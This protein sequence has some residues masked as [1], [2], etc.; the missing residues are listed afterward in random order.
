MSLIIYLGLLTALTAPAQVAAQTWTACNPLNQTNCPP[1]TALGISNATYNF[2][3]S[4]AGSTWNTT[5]GN[6]VY[7][8]QGAEF[9]ISQKGEAPTI[10]SNFYIFFG[11]V[12]VWMKA[13][14]GQGV[15]STIVL[16]SDDLDEVDLEIVGSN[17]THIENNY[18]GKGNTT[19]EAQRAIWY[20]IATPAQTGFHNYTTRWTN[21]SLEWYV[22]GT[23]VRTLNYQDANGGASY[24]QTPMNVRIGVW[25]AGDPSNSNW[26]VA[27]AGG[28]IDYNKGPYTMYLQSARITDFSSGAEYK[29][30]DKSGTW[31]SNDIVA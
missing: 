31:Q 5:N 18:Y 8:N 10:Q 12:E 15:V 2:A 28:A 4:S 3:T 9:T 1:D 16:E 14:P 11:E 29:Y 25:P 17:A 19:G 22:D 27:W 13:A 23:V 26:T 6:I 21:E 30:G 7:G 20:P 24:P